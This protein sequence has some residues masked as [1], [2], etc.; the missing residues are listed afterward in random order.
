[1]K[2]IREWLAKPNPTPGQHFKS[3]PLANAA[4]EVH[5]GRSRTQKRQLKAPKGKS[6]KSYE[7][8]S[9]VTKTILSNV[10]F[11]RVRWSVDPSADTWEPM[12][13]LMA[14]LGEAAHHRLLANMDQPCSSGC[15][16]TLTPASRIGHDGHAD[17]SEF[18]EVDSLW[19]RYERT[20]MILYRTHW[21]GYPHTNDTFEP[22]DALVDWLGEE[23]VVELEA[24][25]NRQY[26]RV[27]T[28]LLP[29]PDHSAN[30]NVLGG[31]R[32]GYTRQRRY[33][34]AH[35]AKDI[36]NLQQSLSLWARRHVRHQQEWTTNRVCDSYVSV[37]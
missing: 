6:A 33:I 31:V 5:L 10:E 15:D 12:S 29:D 34:L 32:M 28:P 7:I 11:V 35:F 16:E 8:K 19:D 23:V 36:E 26:Q 2:L 13:H 25:R 9:Y 18:Y 27:P 17:V 4:K 1:M 22:R 24:T 37:V 21:F 20:G 3:Q 14:E 30:N